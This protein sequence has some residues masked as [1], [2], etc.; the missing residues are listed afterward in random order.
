MFMTAPAEQ[1]RHIGDERVADQ[2]EIDQ[3]QRWF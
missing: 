2:H 3:I 1:R